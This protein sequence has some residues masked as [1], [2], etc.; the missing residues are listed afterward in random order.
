MH[1]STAAQ[2]LQNES[3]VGVRALAALGSIGPPAEDFAYRTRSGVAHL[4]HG[5]FGGAP[6]P[7][8]R[9]ESRL[10]DA[11]NEYPDEW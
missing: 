7:V 3:G 4:N 9:V 11:W 1:A 8:Q 2:P 5:S 6:L 10:R